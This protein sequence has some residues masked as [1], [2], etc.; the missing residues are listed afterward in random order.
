MKNTSDKSRG[1]T[2]K[3][4]WKQS[5]LVTR[6]PDLDIV[7]EGRLVRVNLQDPH[8]PIPNKQLSVNSA[9]EIYSPA[10]VYRARF[11]CFY[12]RFSM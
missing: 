7:E 12:C 4:K 1:S 8:F 10:I 6:V 5:K 9:S 3:K 11:Y 2:Q